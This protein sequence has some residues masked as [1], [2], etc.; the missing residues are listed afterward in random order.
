LL[1]SADYHRRILAVTFTNKATEEMKS[2]IVRELHKMANRED[3]KYIR[4]MAEATGIHENDLPAIAKNVL[5]YLLH[6]YSHFAVVT[7]DSF[8]Q[9]VIRSFAR[10]MGLYAGYNVELDQDS[11]LDESTNLM[12]NDIDKNDF[13]KDWLVDWAKRKIEEGKSWNFKSDV[14]R[15][16]SEIFSEELQNIEPELLRETTDKEGLERYR[17]KLQ[18]LVNSYWDYLQGYGQMAISI[19]E[20]YGL[21]VDHFTRKSQGVGGYFDKLS[22]RQ[23][24]NINSYVMRALEGI[25][26]WHGKY[27]HRRKNTIRDAYED[28]GLNEI[29]QTMTV[30]QTE[31]AREVA[32]AAVILKQI[33]VLGVLCDLMRY[34]NGYTRDQNLFLL[35]EASGFLK[36][37]IANADTPFIYERVGSFYNYFMIDEFQDTSSIQWDNFRPLIANSIASGY[38]DWIVGDVKQSIYRWRNTDW[39]IL[40]EQVERDLGPQYVK[41]QNL[42]KNWRSAPEVVHFNNTFFREAVL[43]LCGAFLTD[44]EDAADEEYLHGLAASMTEAYKDSY[45]HLPERQGE[46][47]GYVHLSAIAEEKDAEKT[48]RDK[49]LEE[50]PRRIEQL[51]DLGYGLSDIAILVREN[52][53]GQT[54]AD[55]LLA[56]RQANPDSK[57]RYDVLSNESLLIGNSPVVKWLV[58]AMRYIVEPNDLINRAYL[59]HEYETYLSPTLTSFSF[60][61]EEPRLRSL[62]VYELSDKLIHQYNL[63][64][65]AGQ[66]PF[67]RAFQDIL[68]QYTRREATDIR[69]FLDWWEGEKNRKYV[70]MPDNQDAIRLITIHKSKG[71][72]FD[73]VIIPFCDWPLCKTGKTLWCQPSEESFNDIKLLP[74][75]FEP[76]LRNTIFVKEYL[77]EKMLSY[78]DNL[79]LLYVA[80]TRARKALFISTLRQKKDEFVSIKDLIHRIYN[81]PHCRPP[82]CGDS[83]QRL[84]GDAPPLWREGELSRGSREKTSSADS[85]PSSISTSSFPTWGRAGAGFPVPHITRNSAYFITDV[86]YGAQM[87]KG[88]LLHDIF[89]SIVTITDL[90]HSLN[91]MITEGKL[92]EAERTHIA[93][94]VH[95][96]L[97]NPTVSRWFAPGLQVKTEAEILLPDGSIARPDRIVFE[98]G[99][100]QVIDYKFGEIESGKYRNQVLRYMDHLRKMGYASV[101]GF[102]WY[103]TLNKVEEVKEREV[104]LRDL[105]G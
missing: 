16:G 89:R 19:M 67:L 15:L 26:G 11:V 102:L 12:L 1:R 5:A 50:L 85:P 28:G 73:A 94:M 66:T 65:N 101:K 4:N 92:S 80:F 33:N 47:K 63:Y 34:V 71:L 57:Y 93:D 74:L 44:E 35:S 100:I 78:I 104:S 24:A 22:K 14:L 54:I 98:N 49:V 60:G 27:S 29:L 81:Q 6:D 18:Q 39:K 37:I 10:E 2:R 3:E 41:V 96:A 32:T 48:W 42:D 51:Q 88:R 59:Q 17:V 79:N 72:E 91:T 103:V 55:T 87:N 46:E 95:R 58:A 64:Q 13:L 20:S 84:P 86:T 90:E 82:S 68:L 31:H 45:Q 53:E 52:K 30:Y 23:E 8:F 40:S 70:T 38:R 25:E 61:D 76:A 9:K 83:S 56:Y 97:G 36:T 75:K 99:H 43:Q 62:P 77:R 7:I 21:E 69:S 105:F